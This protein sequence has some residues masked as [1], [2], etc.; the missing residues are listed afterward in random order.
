[1]G[2]PLAF[3]FLQIPLREGR[4]LA[5]GYSSRRKAW[6]GH[7]GGQ[8]ISARKARERRAKRTRLFA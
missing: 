7:R 1:M 3:G 2:L 5:F 6:D 4:P 8:I